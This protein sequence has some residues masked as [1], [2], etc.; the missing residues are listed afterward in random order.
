GDLLRSSMPIRWFYIG[1]VFY[2]T[3]CLQCAF[4]VTLTFQKII[5]FTDWVVGHAHLVMF[6]VF[7]FWIMGMLVYLLPRVMQAAGWYRDR[8]NHWH[9]WLTGIG[10]LVMFFDLT[11]A[12]LIQGFKWRDL[13]PWE[14]SLTASMPFWLLRSITGTMIMVGQVFFLANIWMTWRHKR[15]GGAATPVPTPRVSP[16]TA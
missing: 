1:M 8:W 15:L 11:I 5:H 7:G 6:G 3:T 10:M 16:V 13:A 9:F 12:G 4:Q 2:F 14:S